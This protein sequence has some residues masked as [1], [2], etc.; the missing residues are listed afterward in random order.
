MAHQMIHWAL[1]SFIKW[2]WRGKFS[3]TGRKVQASC[4]ISLKFNVDKPGEFQVI[5]TCI[6]VPFRFESISIQFPLCQ[7]CNRSFF[8][9]KLYASRWVKA[10]PCGC[11][12]ASVVA[13]LLLA[14]IVSAWDISS[15]LHSDR[16]THFTGNMTRQMCSV[17]NILL[18]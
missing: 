15:E 12:T 10:F 3:K 8:F 17:Y 4:N 16:R 13:K 2:Y 11:V 9:Y 7:G 6:M 1:T 18:T 14:K 5:L